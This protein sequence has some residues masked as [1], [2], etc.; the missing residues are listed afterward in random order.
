MLGGYLASGFHGHQV[1]TLGLRPD[2]EYPVDLT[3]SKPDF[4]SEKFDLVVHAAGTEEQ[5]K[6]MALNLEGTERLLEALENNPPECF[7]YVSSHQVYS[8]DAG[9]EITEDT[10][11]WATTEAGKSK[12]L[13]E[14][15]VKKW[16]ERN[17]V[18]LTIIRPARMFGT[19]VKGETLKLFN[20]ALSGKYIHIRDNNARVSVVCA[21]DVARAIE[22]VYEKGGVYNAADGNPVRFIDLVEAMTANAG[23]K[24]RMTHLPATWAEWLWRL[25]RWVPFIQRNL[26]PHVVEER[27]KTRILDGSKLSRVAGIDYH[28]TISVIERTDRDYPYA[29][30]PL[31]N[32][33]QSGENGEE[34]KK[35]YYHEC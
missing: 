25:G 33:K 5:D 12:A 35:Q 32:G 10:N 4:G 3:L 1:K 14:E 18:T 13:A 29:V 28:D 34:V 22:N 27:M 6:A 16:C 30:H 11:T 21:Y 26:A 8:R 24:K 7:V 9:E 17:E 20:D 19:G 31:G 15:K 23:A 2:S